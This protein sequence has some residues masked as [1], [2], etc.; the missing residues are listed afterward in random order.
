MACNFQKYQY[1]GVSV[2]RFFVEQLRCRIVTHGSLGKNNTMVD[3]RVHTRTLINA[4]V[5]ITHSIIE[6][7]IFTIRDI[8]DGGVFVVVGE[9]LFP[10]LGSVV[11]VQMQGVPFE[12]PVLDM[13]VVRKGGDGFGLKFLNGD[14]NA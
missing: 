14:E 4:K 13:V 5:K 12:A 9:S 2:Q 8:S 10:P 7:G 6:E 11:K 1:V 3:K